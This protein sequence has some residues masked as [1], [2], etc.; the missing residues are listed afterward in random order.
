M[1]F[2]NR[3]WCATTFTLRGLYKAAEGCLRDC[4][5]IHSKMYQ[6]YGVDCFFPFFVM[7]L[8]IALYL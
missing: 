8:P 5:R 3:L 7:G 1:Q 2:Y 4:Y 6:I